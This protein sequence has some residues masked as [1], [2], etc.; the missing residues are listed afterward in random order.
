MS[1][2]RKLSSK[3]ASVSFLVLV[4][5]FRNGV[6]PCRKKMNIE[7]YEVAYRTR[8]LGKESLNLIGVRDI[9]QPEAWLPQT[10]MIK[11]LSLLLALLDL[12]H[13]YSCPQFQQ[14]WQKKFTLYPTFWF[15]H[16]VWEHFISSAS[17]TCQGKGRK[18]LCNPTTNQ[19]L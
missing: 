12:S 17:T 10:S 16:C 15:H 3:F 4:S 2:S 1:K 8:H 6:W 11:M 18:N 13:H 5:D 9:K 7:I 19:I 14:S